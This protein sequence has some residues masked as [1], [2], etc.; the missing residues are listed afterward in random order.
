VNTSNGNKSSLH[1]PHN[2]ECQGCG[3]TVDL[4]HDGTLVEMPID[5]PASEQDV[6]VWHQDCY[7]SFLDEGEE[8]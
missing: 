5:R 7:D 4:Q 3:E 8:C 1:R 6:L 2:Q